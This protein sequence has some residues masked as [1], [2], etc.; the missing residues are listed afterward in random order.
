MN[1]HLIC[2]STP[3]RTSVRCGATACLWT[4]GFLLS[5][6]GG[7]QPDTSRSAAR[8][9]PS[10]SSTAD[11]STAASPNAKLTEQSLAAAERQA[12]AADNR[13]AVA[14]SDLPAGQIAP[15]RAYLS[16]E[17][18][19][20]ALAVRIPAYRFYNGSTGAHFFTTDTSE[21]DNVIATLSPPF[22]YE[23]PAF[24]VANAYSPGLSPVHRF[25]NT[26]TG[27]HFYTI[28]E[29]ERAN[30]VATLPHYSYEG[31]AYHASQVPGAGLVPFYRFYVASKGFH[32]YTASETEKNSIVAN[33]G[34][35]YAFEGI[36]YYVLDSNWRT[37]KLPHTGITTSQC[38]LNGTN[39]PGPCT[40]SNAT[41]LNPQQDGQRASINAM[42]YSAVS[43]Q[44]VTSCVK[45]N[46]TGLVWEGKEASGTR[47]GTNTYTNTGNNS[48]GDASSYVAAVNALN[49]C[50]FSDWRLPTV[51][52][53]QSILVYGSGTDPVVNPTWFPNTTW[54]PTSTAPG[55]Y[56][57]SQQAVFN[58]AQAW[59]VRFTYDGGVTTDGR[60]LGKA[61][62]LV[63]GV[64]AA[65]PRFTYSTV[66]YGSDGAN[67]VVTDAWTGL[68]W[69]RCEQ[70]RVWNGS[71][72]TG[73]STTFSHNNALLHAAAQS[74]WRM[75][76][77]KELGSLVDLNVNITGTNHASIDPTAF[78]GAEDVVLWA[79][80]PYIGF[81]YYSWSVYAAAG[82]ILGSMRSE[83]HSVRLVRLVP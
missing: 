24:S 14:L 23:G 64:M 82:Y 76:N 2:T 22:S 40:D 10:I 28:S 25:Y 9:V 54:L 57:T 49:L 12:L 3:Y 51:M 36:G 70:G 1:T 67:N 50:G 58:N 80:T 72:C 53:L 39:T 19:R 69:R 74:G 61:V 48:P 15:K 71:A 13:S 47:A 33:L 77:I 7:S 4:L 5:A 35:V 34:A 66:A 31:V 43:G 63:R 42:S 83:L 16:G 27:V 52:E 60:G 37:E 79:S 6:C 17:V 38:Y 81:N 73:A 11:R 30:V 45:D 20:K 44:P 26:Q 65:G 21:R 62:R 18:A 32:F 59:F 78:P 68:Q 75:P 29:T 8:E 46:I 55:H 56:W 41:G